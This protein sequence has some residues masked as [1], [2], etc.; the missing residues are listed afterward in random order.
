M[1]LR[2][3]IVANYMGAGWNALMN[4]AFVSVYIHYLGAEAYGLVGVFAVLQGLLSLLD[5]GMAPTISREMARLSVTKGDAFGA[6]ALLQSVE[7]VACLMAVLIF[8]A[9]WAGSGWLSAHWLG[10]NSLPAG[11]V[12]H[13]I[14]I[15]GALVG[16][17]ILE[18]VYRSALI[19]M[20]RQVALNAILAVVATLRGAGVCLVLAYVDHSPGGFFVW[21]LLVAVASVLVYRTTVT[22]M[23]PR[24]QMPTPLSLSPLFT[25]WQFAAG[26]MVVA[27]MSLLLT[28]LDKI[29]L[30][31]LLPLDEF[32]RYSLA[33]VIAQAPLGLV[34]PVA[35]AFYPRF[36]QFNAT[37]VV[38]ELRLAYH[39]ASQLITVLLG[40]A[41]VFL[42]LFGL[43][44]LTAW[45]GNPALA[46]HIF[47]LVALLSAGSM[48]NGFMTTPYYLQLSAGWTRLTIGVNAVALLVLIP[49]LLLLVPRFG[50]VAAA[51]L[52]LALNVAYLLTIIPL[53]HRRLLPG[54]QWVWYVKD[55]MLPLALALVVGAILRWAMGDVTLGLFFWPVMVLVGLLMLIGSALGSDRLRDFA[56]A[57]LSHFHAKK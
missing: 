55:V 39:Q 20:Q 6:R 30:A 5:L 26:T 8:V 47:P 19:G 14:G 37:G 31:R 36:T 25:I 35:Q 43:P 16:L 24:A 4:V 13:S 50:A 44:V 3:N 33:V 10:A 9:L 42:L 11:V 45:T 15:M 40:T 38:E 48:I 53:M 29:L 49:A 22:S 17:R 41:T 27:S 2:R 46:A 51:S 32:G 18:N 7:V 21:Q 28:N 57:Q 52:W 34:A 56:R 12:S 23:L 1:S 54:Q